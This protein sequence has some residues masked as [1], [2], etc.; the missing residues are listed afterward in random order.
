MRMMI[1]K[2]TNNLFDWDFQLGEIILLD[3][4]IDWT[5]FDVVNKI[6]NTVG[7]KKV[8]HAGTLDPKATGLLIICTGKST[9]DV[10]SFQGMEKTYVGTI[11]LGKRSKSMDIETD[12]IG[13]EDLSALNDEDI[14]SSRKNFTGNIMQVPPMFSA[15]KHKGKTLYNLARK[16]KKISLEP[17]E[18]NVASFE[19]LKIYKPYLDFEIVCSKGT[20]IRS[21]A[22]DFGE[23]LGCGAVLYSLRRT[24][25]GEFN[26]ID[27]LSINEFVSLANEWKLNKAARSSEYVQ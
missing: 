16:G 10:L 17:R 4:P 19:I 5:S 11:L 9:K 15:I 25:I 27:A 23:L 22:N 24:A 8:G 14:F 13:E 26:V 7:V 3:K 18:V 6:R 2:G 21:I 12:L 20:Y 1:K